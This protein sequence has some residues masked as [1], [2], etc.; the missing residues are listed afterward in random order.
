ME[1]IGKEGLINF[2]NDIIKLWEKGD[3]PFLLHFSG[4][5]ED[6]LIDFFKDNVKEGDWIFSTHRSHYHALLSGIKEDTLKKS[7]I[8]GNSMFIFSKERNFF[9]SSILSGTC[10][11]AA[12]VAW[13]LKNENNTNKVWCF[14]GDGAEEEGHFYESVMMV[15]GHNLPCTFIIEDNNRSVDTS[16]EERMPSKYRVDWPKCVVRY[17][18]KSLYPHAG[19][20]CSHKIVFK[21]N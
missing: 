5:N 9:T 3:L 17:N 7:I 12:G 2:E 8:D 14:I 6:I 18:Y 4:G 20:G 1:F 21:Q 13:A 16:I 11:I 10:C 15:E 19:S